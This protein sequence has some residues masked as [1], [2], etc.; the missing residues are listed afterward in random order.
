MRDLSH[1]RAL[2]HAGFE[3]STQV[4]GEHRD[5]ES[6]QRWHLKQGRCHVAQKERESEEWGEGGRRKQERREEEDVST[7][8]RISSDGGENQGEKSGSG[9]SRTQL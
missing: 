1:P 8:P 5:L 3:L 9:L 7:N 6:L 2:G 4:L